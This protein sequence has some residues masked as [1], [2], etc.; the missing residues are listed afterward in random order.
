ML[1]KTQTQLAWK[2]QCDKRKNLKFYFNIQLF[3]HLQSTWYPNSAYQVGLVGFL[4]SR[5]ALLGFHHLLKGIYHSSMILMFSLHKLMQHLVKP[6]G[7]K[8][9]KR[10]DTWLGTIVKICTPTTLKIHHHYKK[11]CFSL[12]QKSIK[13]TPIWVFLPP[14]VQFDQSISLNES[15]ST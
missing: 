1:E 7:Y 10:N 8:Y 15:I 2:I 11:S 12:L 6:I 5:M 14:F 9:N 13:K 3:I 4:L